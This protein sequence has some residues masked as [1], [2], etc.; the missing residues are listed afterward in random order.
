MNNYPF[1][2]SLHSESEAL[3]YYIDAIQYRNT[4]KAESSEIA[5]HVFRRTN[6]N[7]MLSFRTSKGFDY[8]RNGFV[9]LEVPGMPLDNDK[10]PDEYVD[11]LWEYLLNKIK[12]AKK[13]RTVI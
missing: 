4:H 10:D 12:K 13:S 5:L 3:D 2:R 11:E 8:L 1:D 7:G 6:P 9:T